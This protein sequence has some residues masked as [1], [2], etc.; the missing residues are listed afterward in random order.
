MIKHIV[1][2]KFKESVSADEIALQERKF[3]AL[4]SQL[5]GIDSIEWGTN[6]SSEGLDKG[7]THCF[8]LSFATVKERDAYLPHPQHVQFA[9]GIGPLLEDVLVIDYE[10]K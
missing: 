5:P 3:T 4:K 1:L 8:N 7:F 10:P 9:D 6:A 2:L